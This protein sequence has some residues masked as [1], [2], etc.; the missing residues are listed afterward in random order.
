MRLVES[1]CGG[2]SCLL[3]RAGLGLLAMMLCQSVAVTVNAEVLITEIMYNPDGTD[4]DDTAGFNREW[5]EVYN[6]GSQAVNVGGWQLADLHDQQFASVVPGSLVLQPNEALVLVGDAATFDAQWGT[7]IRRVQL[8]NFPTLA[9]SPGT[10]D[11]SV[12]FYNPATNIGDVVFYDDEGSWPSDVPD[13]ASI[14][15]RP[16]RLTASE[17]GSGSSWIPSMW[18]VY[19]A[20][21]KVSPEGTED[22]A[23]PGFVETVPQQSFERSSDAVWSMVVMPDTQ[24]YVKTAAELPKLVQMTEWIRDHKQEFNIQMVLQEG[25]IVNNNDTDTPTS[26]DQTGDQQ[27]QNAKAAFS[28]LDGVVPY[29][30]SPGNHDY[31]TTSAQNRSTQFNDYFKA[32]DNSLVDPAKGGILAEQLVAGQMDSAVFDFTAPDGREMLVLTLEWG[33]RQAVVNAANAA[34]SDPEYADHTAIMMTHAYMYHDETRYDWSRNQDSNPNNNQ[35]GSPYAYGTAGDTND[36]QDLWEE[37][38]SQHDQFEMVL[39][40]HVGG[41]GVGYLVEDGSAEQ[42]VHQMLFNTQFESN[43]GNGWIRVVEFLDD[44]TTVRV[45]TFSPYHDLM[46]TDVA[47]EFTFQI[48][49]IAASLNGDF[50]EDGVVD[51]ADYSLWR[52]HVGAPYGSLANDW[53]GQTIG[54]AQY[55]LWRQNY[56]RQLAGKAS[57]ANS[58]VPEPATVVIVGL[59]IVGAMPLVRGRK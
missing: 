19:G 45:R 39:S 13:G 22:R 27:W 34:M 50:N 9:N 25:D 7:G 47:N 21:F 41:D 26:G 55:E 17:N 35:G 40:G 6:A 4:R 30:F 42:Q 3:K 8:D 46:K 12:A 14:M 32:T 23:S 58:A 18:G 53:T 57:V 56:G 2:W 5:V 10:S 52:N 54:Q 59:L 43:A 24:N 37:L 11:E 38:V 49:P 16:E 33:P 48:T 28:V 31:G 15:L 51:I 44:G 29:A 36:G 1:V 20:E